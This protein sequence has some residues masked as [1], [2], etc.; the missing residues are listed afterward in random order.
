[1][2]KYYFVT[3]EYQ[4]E[5]GGNWSKANVTM[6]IHPLEWLKDVIENHEGSYR[7]LFYDEIT[8]RQYDLIKGWIN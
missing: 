6:G 2:N 8:E 3:Y 1:M 7:I 5:S 4:N